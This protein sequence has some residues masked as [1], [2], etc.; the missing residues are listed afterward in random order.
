MGSEGRRRFGVRRCGGRS[1]AP[2]AR[3]RAFVRSTAARADC[4][5][6]LFFRQPDA[7]WREQRRFVG[8]S[9]GQTAAWNFRELHGAA[10]TPFLLSLAEDS[11]VDGWAR[12]LRLWVAVWWGNRHCLQ[13]V[14]RTHIGP[15]A[16]SSS[17]QRTA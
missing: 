4:A 12:K 15:W 13:Y 7:F 11:A 9:F 17:L 5:Q 1:G 10:I 8:L 6:H 16:A 14:V 2:A 3:R